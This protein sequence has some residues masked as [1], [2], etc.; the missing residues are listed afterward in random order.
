MNHLILTHLLTNVHYFSHFRVIRLASASIHHEST[1]LC[2]VLCHSGTLLHLLLLCFALN[3]SCP[4]I[5]FLESLSSLHPKFLRTLLWFYTPH[6]LLLSMETRA[7]I[8][9]YLRLKS[10]SQQ[11]WPYK[12]DQNT[13]LVTLAL[14]HKVALIVTACLSDIFLLLSI[15]GWKLWHTHTGNLAVL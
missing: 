8:T 14:S 10:L 1:H 6:S 5:S 4:R 3:F 15:H 11:D 12:W 2:S 13:S 7:V 9:V